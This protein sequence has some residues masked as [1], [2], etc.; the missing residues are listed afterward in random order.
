MS[1][2]LSVLGIDLACR[3]WQDTGTALLSFTAADPPQWQT[4]RTGVISWPTRP[5]S[6]EAMAAAIESFA[7]QHRVQ[8]VSLD[9]PQGWREPDA[10]DRRGVG[11]WCEYRAQ[12]QGKT[13]IYGVTYPGTQ[14]GW[15]RFCIEV[16]ERL[17]AA[18]HGH[19]VNGT[20]PLRLP[21]AA[22]GTY[23]LIEC[24]PTQTW[25]SSRLTP[26]PGKSSRPPADLAA[27][28]ASLWQRYGLP[29]LSPWAGSHDDLQAVVASLPAAG[30]LGAPCVP[31]PLG[32]PGRWIDE[33]NNQPRHWVEGLI[34]DAAPPP[35]N[36]VITIE[37]P[38][39]ERPEPRTLEEADA[40]NP[41]LVDDRED[42]TDAIARGVRLFEYLVR[43]ANG[44]DCIGIG[45]AKFV[46]FIHGVPSFQDVANRQYLP[47][48]TPHVVSLS[49]QVTTAAGGRQSVSRGT[50][51][52]QAGMD[53]FIWQAKRPHPRPEAAFQAT[54]YSEQDWQVI[55]PDGSRRLITPGELDDL[56]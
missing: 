9:G 5:V 39:R 18:G 21:R 48:D 16:F 10:D 49:H 33:G 42:G 47:S 30:L 55:F 38:R 14:A 27:W 54:P 37:L 13:G 15:I 44:G 26:L 12:T 50:V 45:Y 7:V 32:N 3:A 53:T 35:E 43:R 52:I 25:R 11:R 23:W 1:E 28:A 51:R 41:I 31:I 19:L 6:A 24:F 29:Q 40:D 2:G 17:I 34:W 8:G 56:T 46:C 22:S 4:V 20:A 36:F